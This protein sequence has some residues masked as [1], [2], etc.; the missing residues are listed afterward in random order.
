MML[1][2][3]TR[4]CIT[5]H[6]TKHMSSIYNSSFVTSVMLSEVCSRVIIETLSSLSTGE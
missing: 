6:G 4:S 3:R 1:C 5:N 2:K